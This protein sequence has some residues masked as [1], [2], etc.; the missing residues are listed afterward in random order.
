MKTVVTDIGQDVFDTE[1]RLKPTAKERQIEKFND[2]M[3]KARDIVEGFLNSDMLCMV[4]LDLEHE[5]KTYRLTHGIEQ[6]E[7]KDDAGA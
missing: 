6:V 5:G 2:A 4:R 7:P 3:D 1:M